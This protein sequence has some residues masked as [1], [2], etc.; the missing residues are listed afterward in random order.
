MTNAIEE[1][2]QKSDN[3]LFAIL[4]EALESL[5]FGAKPSDARERR[6]RGSKWFQNNLTDI[7]RALCKSAV[8]RQFF[9]EPQASRNS[10]A[11]AV[12]D[13][14]SKSLPAHFG[15]IGAPIPIACVAVLIARYSIA[16]LCADFGD[17]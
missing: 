14:L 15:P 2:A 3:E 6:D 11:A 5:E 1:V 16:K 8:R 10:L 17:Q 13:A 7:R 9:S 4:G 12:L